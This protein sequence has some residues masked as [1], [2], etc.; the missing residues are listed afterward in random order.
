ML[1][2]NQNEYTPGDNESPGV[3]ASGPNGQEEL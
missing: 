3:T 1:E 2:T